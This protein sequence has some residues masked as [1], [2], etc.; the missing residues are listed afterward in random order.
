MEKVTVNLMIKAPETLRYWIAVDAE[1]L[2]PIQG[3]ATVLLT[4]GEEAILFWWMVGNSGDALNVVISENGRE[5]DT[6]QASKVPPGKTKGHGFRRF[7]P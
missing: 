1:E 2:N 7:T 4:K 3:S 6:V 5:I